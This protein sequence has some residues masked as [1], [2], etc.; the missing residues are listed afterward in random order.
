MILIFAFFVAYECCGHMGPP[1]ATGSA[2]PLK[3]TFHLGYN[4]LLNLYR[5]ED[6]NPEIMIINS[7]L[8]VYSHSNPNGCI[9]DE[10]I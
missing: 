5:V 8:Q 9:G 6:A 10:D 2:D 4:M 1:T 3:S 7:F